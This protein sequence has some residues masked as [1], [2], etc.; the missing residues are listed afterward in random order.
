MEDSLSLCNSFK[1]IEKVLQSLLGRHL[2]L[3]L[4][5]PLVLCLCFI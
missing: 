2:Y 3:H 1:S 5:I 4:Q